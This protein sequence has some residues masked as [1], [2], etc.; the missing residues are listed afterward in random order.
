MRDPMLELARDSLP[1]GMIALAIAAF[2]RYMTGE[3]EQGD[4]IKIKDPKINVLKEP[5]IAMF[6]SYSMEHVSSLISMILGE[7]AAETEVVQNEVLSAVKMMGTDGT[8]ICLSTCL[9][10]AS[11]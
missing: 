6:K 2:M 4:A 9:G 10:I 1:L 7:E 3:D 5:C 8:R 11:S